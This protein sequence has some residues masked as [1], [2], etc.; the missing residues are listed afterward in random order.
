MSG[1][2]AR[3]ATHHQDRRMGDVT[4]RPR[5]RSNASITSSAHA[6]CLGNRSMPASH[7]SRPFGMSRLAVLQQNFGRLSRKRPRSIRTSAR[8]KMKTSG[9]P[10]LTH[11]LGQHLLGP[12]EQSVRPHAGRNQQIHR[13]VSRSG[14]EKL[15]PFGFRLPR[16]PGVRLLAPSGSSSSGPRASGR[17][18]ICRGPRLLRAASSSCGIRKASSASGSLSRKPAG[19]NRSTTVSALRGSRPPDSSAGPDRTGAASG[20]PGTRARVRSAQAHTERSRTGISPAAHRL[21]PEFRCACSSAFP[22]PAV[23]NNPVSRSGI[24]GVNPLLGHFLEP[25]HEQKLRVGRTPGLRRPDR[26][27]HVRSGS[28]LSPAAFVLF[29]ERPL[30]FQ[31]AGQDAPLPVPGR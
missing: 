23:R 17:P 4:R 3:V 1:R 13:R 29:P 5:F 28:G 12:V 26:P 7:Q 27:D 31:H 9:V 10:R 2:T 20:C 11:P 21:V 15:S 25:P 22:W 14:V 8:S 24:R 18:F 19:L 6:S 16:F 30:A